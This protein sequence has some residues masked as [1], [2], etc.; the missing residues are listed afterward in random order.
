MCEFKNVSRLAAS[1]SYIFNV[2]FSAHSQSQ[3]VRD[4]RAHGGP[5]WHR[6]S[7]RQWDLFTLLSNLCLHVCSR[8]IAGEAGKCVRVCVALPGSAGVPAD[9][10]DHIPAQAEKHHRL[11]V[12]CPGLWQ[13]GGQLIY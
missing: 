4:G 5:Q 6:T 8:L 2:V 10:A 3:N 12:P 11:L 9:P 1:E 7:C 13:R